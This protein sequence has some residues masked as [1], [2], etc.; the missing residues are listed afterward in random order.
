MQSEFFKNLFV[1]TVDDFFT[2]EENGKYFVFQGSKNWDIYLVDRPK[3]ISYDVLDNVK[4][5]NFKEER[6]FL[7]YMQNFDLIDYSIE[8]IDELNSYFI[9]V[10][11]K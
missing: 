4:L 8:H 1:A 9:L 6:H 2:I 11:C 5:L 3:K 7:K 10:N